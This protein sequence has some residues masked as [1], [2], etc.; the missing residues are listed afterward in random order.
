M[1]DLNYQVGE[2]TFTGHLAER[3]LPEL[4]PGVLVIPG[5]GG[6][7]AHARERTEMLADSGYVAFAADLFGEPI[8]GLDHARTVTHALLEDWAELRRRCNAALEI[9]RSQ[10]GVDRNRLAVIGFCFGGQAALEFGRSGAEVR[11][12]VG[13]HAQLTTP[14]PQDSRNIGGKVL[15]C[16]GDQDCFVFADEREAFLQ[17]MTEA[18]VDCQMLLF[19]GVGHSF[20]DRHAEASGVP[21]LKYDATA[22]RRAWA[23]MH[24]LLA[25][26]FA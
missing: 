12:I 14:R 15:V 26:A 11:A 2:R 4:R 6:L 17:S 16:L 13:F 9:L 25:E 8:L 23:A 18:S 1:A 21:G 20:T 24:A 3:A 7:G 5:G 19:S 22:D 10:P